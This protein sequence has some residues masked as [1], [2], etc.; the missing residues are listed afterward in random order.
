[1]P[2][3]PVLIRPVDPSGA[4]DRDWLS[5]ARLC[6]GWLAALLKLAARTAGAACDS[7]QKPG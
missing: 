5:S 2:S 4:S 1:M 7:L 3:F 6:A